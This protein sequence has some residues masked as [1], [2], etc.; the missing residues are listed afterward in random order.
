[1]DIDI[2]RYTYN[3]KEIIEY[4]ILLMMPRLIQSVS[5]FVFEKMIYTSAVYPQDKTR[6]SFIQSALISPLRVLLDCSKVAI[7]FG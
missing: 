2:K 7:S 3:A 5:L 4:N 6:M 1:M